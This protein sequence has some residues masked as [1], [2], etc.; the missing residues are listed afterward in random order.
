[1]H[2]FIESSSCL[3]LSVFICETQFLNRAYRLD[4]GSC[5]P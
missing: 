3:Y 4:H 2:T 1:M 5:R